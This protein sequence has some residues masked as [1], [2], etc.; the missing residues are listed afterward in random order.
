MKPSRKPWMSSNLS[1]VSCLFHASTVSAR[2]VRNL[3][4]LPSTYNIRSLATSS[5]SPSQRLANKVTVVTGA[6]SGLGR[7][8][9]L[10]FAAQGTRFVLCADL[11]PEAPPNEFGQIP[12]DELIRMQYGA[13]RAA[14]A[15]TDVGVSADVEGC[16]RE[17]VERGGLGRL[18]V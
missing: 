10:A 12:T 17:A 14:F 7:A 13:N 4:T 11:K 6:S 15:K 2:H 16:V 1:P 9:A 3:W 5:H 18:H 8:I